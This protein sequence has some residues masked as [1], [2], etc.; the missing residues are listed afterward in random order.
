MK[1]IITLDT[2]T[3]NYHLYEKRWFR[4]RQHLGTFDTYVSA[5]LGMQDIVQRR[6]EKYTFNKYGC[7]DLIK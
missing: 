3:G 6:P 1:Y 7:I 5:Y 2:E 4:R